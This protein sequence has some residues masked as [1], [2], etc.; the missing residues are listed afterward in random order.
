MEIVPISV[1]KE[2]LHDSHLD[3]N[4]NLQSKDHFCFG[5]KDGEIFGPARVQKLFKLNTVSVA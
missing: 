4:R 2:F 5:R 1:F 3:S